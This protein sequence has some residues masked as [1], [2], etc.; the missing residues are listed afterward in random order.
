MNGAVAKLHVSAAKDESGALAERAH[1]F[2]LLYS[3]G[4]LEAERFHIRPQGGITRDSRNDSYSLGNQQG[5]VLHAIYLRFTVAWT[6]LTTRTT[7]VF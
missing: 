3:D 6:A 5:V 2:S 4:A 1:L 7:T